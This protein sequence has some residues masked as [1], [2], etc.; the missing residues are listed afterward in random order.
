VHLLGAYI[1]KTGN[2]GNKGNNAVQDDTKPVPGFSLVPGNF[3]EQTPDAEPTPAVFPE[4]SGNIQKTGNTTNPVQDA[5][6]PGVPDVPARGDI[7]GAPADYEVE[8]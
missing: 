4:A 7:R 1:S 6:V 5:S 8:L 3:R 2:K